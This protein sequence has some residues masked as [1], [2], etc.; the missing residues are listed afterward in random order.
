[1]TET[2]TKLLHFMET[3]VETL[4]PPITSPYIYKVSKELC[5]G[6]GEFFKPISIPIGPLHYDEKSPA[7][8]FKKWFLKNFIDRLIPLNVTKNQ[9]AE[10][11][12]GLGTQCRQ[13]YR[14]IDEQVI[15]DYKFVQIM[16]L[17][18]C[19]IMELLFS[20][21]Y[22]ES[23]TSVLVGN[24]QKVPFY[25]LQQD[26][27]RMENQLPFLVLTTLADL[28]RINKSN[29]NSES[30]SQS[31]IHLALEFFNISKPENFT[32]T[33]NPIPR[34][35][36]E[37]AMNVLFH[38]NDDSS[39][40]QDVSTSTIHVSDDHKNLLE[41]AKS[42]SALEM[43][44]IKIK[45]GDSTNLTKIEYNKGVLV[46]PPLVIQESTSSLFW[47]FLIFDMSSSSSRIFTSYAVLMDT[48]INNE[49]DVEVL[50]RKKIL[51]SKNNDIASL[52]SLFNDLCANV[53]PKEFYFEPL[54]QKLNQAFR[55]RRRQ[56]RM[57][58]VHNYYDVRWEVLSSILIFIF[59][60][61][62]TMFAVLSYKPKDK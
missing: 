14:D 59:T 8:E 13:Y 61:T 53:S 34:H 17:D 7:Q 51:I 1:M 25:T 29:K 39:S 26:L 19:F 2:Q 5:N 49:K 52:V 31:V 58:L 46:I 35:L 36:L 12:I 38:R 28:A 22:K 33:D 30:T 3:E 57:Y 45:P 21:E 55:T 44:G 32:S 24:T 54:M 40:P 48:L 10:V 47:N 15:T 41:N 11:M 18:G 50:L 9:L 4:K 43:C 62:Q 6:H 27:L 60:V 16:L 20:Q 37:L 23:N 56:I 42:A